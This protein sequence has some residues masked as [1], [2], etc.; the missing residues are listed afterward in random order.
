MIEAAKKGDI[1]ARARAWQRQDPALCGFRSASRRNAADGG[2]LP[3]PSR[4]RRYARRRRAPR[5]TSSRPPPSDGI[6]APTRAL[7]RPDGGQRV[8]P[9][10]AGRR[11]ISPRSSATPKRPSG[12]WMPAPRRRRSR[13]NSLRNTPLHAAIAGGHAE[14]A[15]LLIERGAD[16][17]AADAGGAH[18][19]AHRRGSG[20]CRSSRRCSRAAPIRT[21]WTPKTGRRCRAPPRSTRNR[22]VNSS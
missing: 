19:A 11:C 18:A 9:T 6:D 2:A 10:T 14:S 8:S 21:R 16:V 1:G 13:S 7:A 3:R 20:Y 17:N 4:G 15:L 5:S 12:C 22:H